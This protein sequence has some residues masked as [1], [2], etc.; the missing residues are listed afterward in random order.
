M[1]KKILLAVAAIVCI[2]VG[3]VLAFLT[4]GGIAAPLTTVVQSETDP[5][6]PERIEPESPIAEQNGSPSEESLPPVSAAVENEPS[7]TATAD[8][9]ASPTFSPIL[10]DDL[11][12][13]RTMVGKEVRVAFDVE[14]AGGKTN[15]YLNSKKDFLS[16]DCFTVKIVTRQAETL[17]S[18]GYKNFRAQILH[19]RIIA[20]G[21]LLE[22]KEQL[23]LVV[24]DIDT[25]M[26]LP[27]PRIARTLEDARKDPLG[28]GSPFAD[29]TELV[30]KM[31][32]DAIKA[33]AWNLQSGQSEPTTIANQIAEF[34]DANLFGLSEVLPLAFDDY[35]AAANS[36]DDRPFK[37][38]RGGSGGNDRL[39]FIYDSSRL[40]LVSK[41]EPDKLADVTVYRGNLRRPLFC[42]F[43]DLKTKTRFIAVLVHQAR[44]D[45]AMRNNQAI[46]LREWA[47]GQTEAIVVMGD[48]NYDYDFIAGKGNAAFEELN[49]DQI[50]RWIQP[51]KFVDTCWTDENLD[52][53]NDYPA[54]IL[55]GFFVAGPARKWLPKARVI[56]RPGDF[57]DNFATSDHRPNELVLVPNAPTY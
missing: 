44:G 2:V 23:S 25:Q 18:R 55:D 12:T 21:I 3:C 22:A 11:A 31:P 16:P 30:S 51:E 32:K 19:E 10:A 38:V 27:P 36:M 1:S 14:A 47:R 17:E 54:S 56:V 49:R 6:V 33:I 42:A 45:E 52:F 48:F 24:S 20:N 8:P 40:E 28:P 34:K 7:T 57:P 26:T 41:Q 53:I 5:N 35:L 39:Q 15:I 9:A 43:R 46:G 37:D 13:L 4:L 50:L 29:P